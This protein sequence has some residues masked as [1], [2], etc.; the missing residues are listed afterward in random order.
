MACKNTNGWR[1]TTDCVTVYDHETQNCHVIAWMWSESFFHGA[2]RGQPLKKKNKR[3]TKRASFCILS[4]LIY[5]NLPYYFWHGLE[6][7]QKDRGKGNI[8][9]DPRPHLYVLGYPRQLYGTF[10]WNLAS[11]DPR[12]ARL[13]TWQYGGRQEKIAVNILVMAC[14]RIFCSSSLV[15]G[16]RDTNETGFMEYEW[17]T[18][19]NF[20]CNN[21]WLHFTIGLK[22][23]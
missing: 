6:G 1:Y 16:R 8:L 19:I 22:H 12:L 21:I 4:H 7:R 14:A 18:W 5:Q 13:H 20:Y 9:K 10:I 15:S 11:A 23:I 17:Q 2:L 3:I